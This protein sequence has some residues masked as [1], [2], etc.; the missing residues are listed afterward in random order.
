LDGL[1]NALRVIKGGSSKQFIVIAG[2]NSGV[3]MRAI[4]P[5]E[6]ARLMGLPNNYI[7]PSNAVE[8]LS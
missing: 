2:A 6:A 7:L 3:R 5:R 8:A 4:A 1:A